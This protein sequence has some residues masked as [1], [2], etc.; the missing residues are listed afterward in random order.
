MEIVN[1]E[2][3]AYLYTRIYVSGHQVATCPHTLATPNTRTRLAVIEVAL[4]GAV[5]W[6]N[7]GA[8]S[9]YIGRTV[10]VCRGLPSTL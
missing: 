6:E 3:I 10:A 7:E 8:P 9:C 2:E 1:F 4:G 5:N